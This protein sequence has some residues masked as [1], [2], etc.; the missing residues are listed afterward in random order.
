VGLKIHQITKV[1]EMEE[2][3]DVKGK[4]GREEGARRRNRK[5]GQQ[6]NEHKRVFNRHFQSVQQTSRVWTEGT[7]NSLEINQQ[8]VQFI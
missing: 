6:D 1:R 8:H 4:G 7:G 5:G 2:G 3:R